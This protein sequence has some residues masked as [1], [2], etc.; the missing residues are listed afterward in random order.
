MPA[1]RVISK[2]QRALVRKLAGCGLTLPQI[3]DASGIAERSLTRHLSV[4]MREGRS[5]AV[6][7]IAGTLYQ[8]ALGGDTVSCLFY[9]KCVGGWRETTR[10][11]A[12]GADGAPLAAGNAFLIPVV[13][14]DQWEALVAK[15]QAKLAAKHPATS[16]RAADQWSGEVRG[17]RDASAGDTAPRIPPVPETWR[18]DHE[19]S[20]VLLTLTDG[21]W[22]MNSMHDSIE[23]AEKRAAQ[24]RERGRQCA[25]VR[26]VAETRSVV[27]DDVNENLIILR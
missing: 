12:T 15:Q 6:G 8:K 21:A 19:G 25:V 7:E 17:V 26:R 23:D 1:K 9:L 27:R 22:I 13:D 3:A 18:T 4:E 16:K 11:E 5:R 24:L 2:D 10:I 14:P 20:H